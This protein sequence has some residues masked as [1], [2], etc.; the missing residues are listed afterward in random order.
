MEGSEQAWSAQRLQADYPSALDHDPPRQHKTA[1]RHQMGTFDFIE[2]PLSNEKDPAEP[3][4]HAWTTTPSKKTCSS[5]QTANFP[6]TGQVRPS[7]PERQIDLVTRPTLV[8][9]PARTAR[10]RTGAIPSIA[11]PAAER[12]LVEVTARP[13]R[14]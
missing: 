1:V 12:P 8:M 13:F 10:V 9:T 6:L 3:S 5:D 14:E 4:T 7:G 2:K 11:E